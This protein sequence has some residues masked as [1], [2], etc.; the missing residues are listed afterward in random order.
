M[1]LYQSQLLRERKITQYA[2]RT[3]VTDMLVAT[4]ELAAVYNAADSPE[5][6]LTKALQRAKMARCFSAEYLD[7]DSEELRS[8]FTGVPA[9]D[10]E[11]IFLE[12]VQDY[13][14]P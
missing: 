9:E 1:N 14:R 8:G 5:V 13:E 7:L 10:F 4:M 2:F 12:P 6:Q 3:R 11:R